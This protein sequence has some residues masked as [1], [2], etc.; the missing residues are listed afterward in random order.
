MADE[1]ITVSASEPAPEPTIA[2]PE[3][4]VE[5]E[6]PQD[7]TEPEAVAE[8]ETEEPVAEAEPEFVTVER[9]GKTYQIPKELEG[10]LLMQSDYTKK[11]QSVSEKAKELE[12]REAGIAQQ[13][14]AT[15]EEL[16][17]RALVLQAKAELDQYEALDWQ[18][19]WDQDPLNAGKHQARYQMLQRE[20]DKTNASLT[21]KQ[22]ERTQKA[23]RDF[24]TR[25]EQTATFAREK[26]P[27]W[28]PEMTESLVKLA[29]DAGVPDAELKRVWSPAVLKLLHQAH[30]GN[31]AMQKQ[32]T[33][34][35]APAPLAPLATVTGKSTPAASKTLA[36][37]A[38]G[39]DMEAYAAMRKAGRVR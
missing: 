2:A 20:Y 26:I 3:P 31:L 21:A 22:T 25:V 13:L 7:I 34:K 16:R 5:K 37:V 28:K 30:I 9:N 4:V 29:L 23:E 19:L 33:A 39:D 18:A 1:E 14:E 27:G 12:A 15:E 6:V 8:P 32:A 10:E 17:D 24:A 38:N 36:D 11:T 35:P